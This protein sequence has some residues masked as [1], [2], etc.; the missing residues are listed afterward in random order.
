M[1]KT[2][3]TKSI[4]FVGIL[5][6][7]LMGVTQVPAYWT[8]GGPYGGYIHS[9]AIAPTDPDI[10]YSA[11]DNGI[12]K[13][14][15]GGAAWTKTGF[16]ETLAIA[17]QVGP[18]NPNTVWAGTDDGIYKSEDGGSTW[19][20][21]GLTG[22]RVNTIVINPGNPNLLF[23][24]TG[25]PRSTGE[26]AGVFKSTDGGDNWEEKLS[27]GLDAVAALLIDVDDFSCI[28]AGV[29]TEGGG[30]GF[31]RSPDGGDSWVSRQVGSLW[32]WDNVVALAMTP[33]GYSSPVI[34][35]VNGSDTDVFKSIDQGDSWTPANTPFVSPASPWAV[36]V[37]PNE[38]NV[39][40]VG[41]HY[42]Q[43]RFYKSTDAGGTWSIKTNGLPP[44]VPSD[45]VIDPRNSDVY[46]GLSEG[47]VYKSNDEAESWHNSS[48]G[49][50]N[51]FL[52]DLA[53]H[54]TSSDMV[55]AA[56][57]GQG[58]HL[59]K[60]TNGGTSWNYL[61]G[62][63]TNRGAVAIDPQ[64]SMTLFTGFGWALR[65]NPIC[66][67]E[68]STDG[69]QTWTN[70]G[71]LFYKIGTVWLGFSD[72]WVHPSDSNTILVAVAGFGIDGGGVYRSTNG[73]ETW[74]KTYSF[75][76][77]TLAADP[78][79][80]Q[81]LYFG[82][83]RWGYVFRS[84]DA[85]ENWTRISPGAEWVWEVRDIEVDL[86][87]DVYAAT[88]EGLMKWNGSDWTKLT[89][90]PTD[91]ITAL[92][93]DRSTTP[94][95]VYVGTGADGVFVSQ[96]EGNTW[97]PFNE[98]LGNLAITKL[99]V[100]SSQPKMLYT[101]TF[102][103]GVWSRR[104][105]P[106]PLPDIKANGSDGPVGI[107]LGNNLS[108]TIEL[109]PGIYT[110]YQADWWCVADAPFGWYYYN[111]GTETWLPGFQVSYQGP[112]FELTPPSEVLNVSDLPTGGYTFYFGVDGNRNGNLDDPLYSDSVE[113]NITP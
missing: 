9:L 57:K 53:V 99:A 62:S 83:E 88:G 68:K 59:G 51:T 71:Y 66:R 72:I 35:A 4:F 33:A 56:I 74:E 44:S 76:A 73:G 17:V 92:A 58:H 104:L 50:N 16:P 36:A 38:P 54:P 77:A 34:Y 3:L 75:W 64:I 15:D 81:I 78:T 84:T 69:G 106:D 82:S 67:L 7:F 32:P 80:P 18:D 24:G 30:P 60:T 47:G 29:Y 113:V 108:V 27:A 48:Q 65:T 90:L 101:G 8:S 22:A 49:M 45:I 12:F 87:T 28:Y 85:G 89:G 13:T 55:Y 94:G 5:C 6:A 86:N 52:N 63:S 109:D 46:A 110:G 105:S 41:T 61:V 93:I 97:I 2:N 96:D 42:Y 103:G 43:G 98:R 21:K 91:D 1:N 40:Y 39:V 19:T 112:L 10:I 26:I 37:D 31:Y 107:T 79:D 20:L 23:A 95:I 14:T 11:T 25:V 111:A 100:S 102:Y 70:T